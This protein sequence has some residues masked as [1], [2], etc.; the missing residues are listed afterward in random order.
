MFFL[1]RL[2]YLSYYFILGLYGWGLRASGER[3][4]DVLHVTNSELYSVSLVIHLVMLL[5]RITILQAT[6]VTA[7]HQFQ[8][9]KYRNLSSKRYPVKASTHVRVCVI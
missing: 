9:R 3:A 8:V 4:F 7:L 6:L 5:L 1:E 2:R